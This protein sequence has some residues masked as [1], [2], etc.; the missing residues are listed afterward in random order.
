LLLDTYDVT[1]GITHAIVA[2]KEAA[3]EFG[4]RLVAV[5]LDSGD[6]GTD[7][8]M[9][10]ARLDEAGMQ[11]VRVLVSGDLDEWKVQAFVDAGAPI[12]GFGVGG[13]LGVGLGSIE[14]GT[15]GG[16]IGA[17]YKLAS[18]GDDANEAATARIKL[19]GG[20]D[21]S[22]WPGRKVPY[23]IGSFDHDVVAL[24]EEAP[25]IGGRA[26][27]Q[28]LVQDGHLINEAPSIGEARERALASLAALPERLHALA[29]SR[30]DR[31]EVEM[32]AALRDL[33][34]RTIAGFTA[35]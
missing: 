3:A 13:N 14:S 17:V 6:L 33:R 34:E 11:D 1:T 19:A 7:S 22:T 35:D 24:A 31:Y 18:Y 8:R 4:H 30:E 26:L 15:I 16:V 32:S 25:P 21:K 23:R 29:V 10:R 9:V 28:P 27:L 12:D 2:G 5:R 20:G